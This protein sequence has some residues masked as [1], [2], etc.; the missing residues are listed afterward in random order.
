[1]DKEYLGITG[2]ASFGKA[3]AEL[4]FDANSSVLVD[5]RVS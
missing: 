4:A 5:K 1:M 2:L 3:A